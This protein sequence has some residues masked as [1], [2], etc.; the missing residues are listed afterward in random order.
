[1]GKQDPTESLV[2]CVWMSSGVLTFRLCDRE[3]DCERCLVDI[4]LREGSRADPKP[5]AVSLSSSG[6]YHPSHLW[7]RVGGGGAVWIGIDDF[8]RRL[9]GRVDDLR[10][11]EVGGFVHRDA[12]ACTLVGEAGSVEMP[13]PLTGRVMARNEEL[14][15]HPESL[16]S[17]ARREPWLLRVRPSRLRDDLGRLHYGRRAAA[18]ASGE[19]DAVHRRLLEVQAAAGTMPDGGTPDSSALDRLDGK[20]R[21]VLVAD[22]LT[23]PAARRKGR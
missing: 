11:P 3:F 19:M 10:L 6:F 2:K 23:G 13:A 20:L 21:S 7:A 12:P 9:L 18:W 5:A 16:R 17:G 1:M 15:A 8:A 22:L 14:I 4:A